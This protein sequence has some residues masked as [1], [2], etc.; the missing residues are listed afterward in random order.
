MTTFI[1]LTSF[2]SSPHRTGIQR[3]CSALCKF[4][5]D[6]DHLVPVML[7]GGSLR[8]LPANTRQLA[9]A[10]FTQST[11]TLGF[12]NGIATPFLTDSKPMMTPGPAARL[13]IPELFYDNDRIVFF[14]QLDSG[15]RHYCYFLVYDFLPLT[16]PGY[17]SPTID[18]VAVH[19]YLLMLRK[20]TNLGFI[21]DLTRRTFFHRLR[22]TKFVAGPVF[23]LG[24]DGLGPRPL[25]PPCHRRPMF[26]ALGTIEQ[27]KNHRLILEAF[28]ELATEMADLH[29]V[30]VGQINPRDTCM[31]E[32]IKSLGPRLTFRWY[33][34]P[35]DNMVRDLVANARA[36][37]FLSAA[38][39]FGLPP[40]E[41]LWL[42]T[43]VIAHP[44]IP[45][46]EPYQTTAVYLVDP[47]NVPTLMHAVRVFAD[48]S[49]Y[50]QRVRDAIALPLPTWTAFAHAVASWVQR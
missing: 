25:L 44:G 2:F 39:G 33:N 49:T 3:V 42:G 9:A 12:N 19:N 31:L 26:V 18:Q 50:P 35:D 38:E 10:H 47:L 20:F 24:A 22:R 45:S 6:P 28:D 14:N 40:L 43:P 37:L 13:L 21:S 30:F 34:S 23:Q 5:P 7:S 46:L 8:I 32:R 29:L 1:D 48:A 15:S 17:F 16:H 36:T 11:L 4:W 41:S 27:R